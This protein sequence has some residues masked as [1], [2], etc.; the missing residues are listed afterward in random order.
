M[1]ERQ[2]Y[3]LANPLNGPAQ[4]IA[5]YRATRRHATG[6]LIMSILAVDR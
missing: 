3:A 6:L 1:N 4:P 5:P 2:A